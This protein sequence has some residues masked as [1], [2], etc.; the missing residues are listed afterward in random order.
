MRAC[1]GAKPAAEKHIWSEFFVSCGS[2]QLLYA[3]GMVDFCFLRC[4]P[5]HSATGG[6]C[7]RWPS[8]A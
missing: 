6:W 2:E 4:A 5:S 7:Q 1:V 3:T 8:P